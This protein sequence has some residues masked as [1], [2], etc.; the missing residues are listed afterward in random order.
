MRLI[1]FINL[2]ILQIIILEGCVDIKDEA[3]KFRTLT[4]NLFKNDSNSRNLRTNEDI[5]LGIQREL[6]KVVQESEIFSTEPSKLTKIY[7]SSTTNLSTNEVSL[8][9]P[10]GI[11]VKLFAYRYQEDFGTIQN[12]ITKNIPVS[13]GK[14]NT[15]IIKE[16]TK[17][18]TI[19]LVISPNGIPGLIVE[20]ND[21]I[22]SDGGGTSS[23]QISLKTHPSADVTIP[24]N[25]NFSGVLLSQKNLEFTPLN[26]SKPQKIYLIG[27]E[28]SLIKKSQNYN[29]II[30]N[31]ITNDF[32]YSKIVTN[33]LIFNHQIVSKPILKE[34]NPISS[35]INFNSPDYT[36]SSSKPGT[37]QYGGSCSSDNT[38]AQSDNN[39]IT[40][41]ALSDGE[42]SN[43]SITVTDPAGN[44]SD[45]LSVRAFTIDTVTPQLVSVTFDN[46][47]SISSDNLSVLAGGF[48]VTFNEAMKASSM[49][50]NDGSTGDIKINCNSANTLRLGADNT[51]TPGQNQCRELAQMSS[52][53]NL[54]WTTLIRAFGNSHC[55]VTDNLTGTPSGTC[56]ATLNPGTNYKLKL[57]TGMTDLA[58][59]AL[60]SENTTLFRTRKT[61]SIISTF[62]D[63]ASD[64]TSVYLAPRFHFDSSMQPNSFIDNVS[65]TVDCV[66]NPT[67]GSDCDFSS[68]Y[69]STADNLTVNP[70]GS[71]P[72]NTTITVTIK[73]RNG[74][75]PYSGIYEAT[76]GIFMPSDYVMNFKT[77]VIDNTSSD[78]LSHG[79]VAFYRFN[80]NAND[81]TNNASHGT[82]SGATLTSGKDNI[83]NTAYSFD[84]NTDKIT[85]ANNSLFNFNVSDNLSFSV[86]VYPKAF[87]NLNGIFSKYQ[88]TGDNDI[89]L[90]I[91]DS[92]GGIKFGSDL[93]SVIIPNALKLNEWQNISITNSNGNT[94]LY[95]NGILK[96]NGTISW[97]QTT[98]YFSIGCDYC[99][100]GSSDTSRF[101]DGKI[102]KLRIYNRILTSAEINLLNSSD[103]TTGLGEWAHWTLDDISGSD[104]VSSRDLT[105]TGTPIIDNGSWS[106]NEN[107][108]GEYILQSGDNLDNFSLSIRFRIGTNA[109]NYDSIFSTEE[110][111]G[112]EGSWQIGMSGN[113]MKFSSTDSSYA[114]TLSRNIWHHLVLTKS[115][116][117]QINIY[118]NNI[119]LD[120]LTLTN[121]SMSRLRVGTNRNTDN[122]WIGDIDDVR[123]YDYVLDSKDINKLYHNY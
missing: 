8:S 67:S 106:L 6:I 92:S 54:S 88:S 25:T 30:G 85:I 59:N 77:S 26:W 17:S 44:T 121:W 28:N 5:T 19:T 12:K 94:K 27:I 86:W 4:L 96:G 71:W 41:N 63:N 61:P 51:T 3:P 105:V 104:N 74:N 15:F 56:A 34:I 36:F 69:D 116:T 49:Q 58:G 45:N 57:A 109:S 119:H 47:T 65:V 81:E 29:V 101:F 76:D 40:F 87:E 48:K 83:S 62:P 10:L 37:I 23:F 84:G 22:T 60:A 7:D 21:N 55:P 108:R 89:Y 97:N 118:A 52:S 114:F 111:P 68:S 66:P 98:N 70:T 93:G 20:K 79:L 43:C 72:D 18:L 73:G 14:S 90:R 33:D 42:Y 16:D 99:V 102:D 110:S 120:T 113:D 24:I 46:G 100:D 38:S 9:I 11:P 115:E 82:V 31:I 2:L 75:F 107:A 80:G 103:N 64:N 91:N 1:F 13:F 78:N 122:L 123:I 50:V 117:N 53:D 32:D 39:T 95:V 112:K 35:L